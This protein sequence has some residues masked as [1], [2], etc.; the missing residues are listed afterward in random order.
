MTI[1]YASDLHLEFPQ[2]RRFLKVNPLKPIGDVLLLAGD[3]VPFA[4]LDYHDNFFNYISNHFQHVWWIPGNHEYYN[5]DIAD[6]SGTIHEEI[7]SNVHLVNNKSV[8]LGGIR[9][10][11]ST[12]WSKIHQDNFWLIEN[13]INDFHV[14]KREGR[15]FSASHFNQLHTES[16][17]FLESELATGDLTKTIVLTHHVPTFMNYPEKYKTDKLNGAFATE[18]SELIEAFPPAY[19][20][21]GHHHHNTENFEIGVTQMLTNQLGYVQLNEHRLFKTDLHVSI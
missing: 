14:I 4:E 17:Q 8:Y 21:Y 7:R 12:L 9:F 6:R 11:F 10:I 5:S 16:V 2:N 18:L 1:Q 20:I 13:N 3:I 15:H 19:W